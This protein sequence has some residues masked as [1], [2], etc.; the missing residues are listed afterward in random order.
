MPVTAR[1]IFALLNVD[2]AM[3]R[4]PYGAGLKPGHRVN[5]PVPL[6]PRREKLAAS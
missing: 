6:F 2:E 5:P 3:A 1:K 4:K